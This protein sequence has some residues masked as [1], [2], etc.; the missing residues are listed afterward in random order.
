MCNSL[1]ISCDAIVFLSRKIDMLGAKAGKDVLDQSKALVRST[2]SDQ[3]K[4]L[5]FRVDFGSMEGMARHDMNVF[6]KMLPEGIYLD[7]LAGSLP[8]NN[9]A[10]L[11]C[12]MFLVQQ[13]QVQRCTCSRL[14]WSIQ[15]YDMSDSLSL[16]AVQDNIA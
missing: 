3:D 15:A 14:T 4:R 11:R 7:F 6:R 5:A 1:S 10:L 13:S 12:Y 9:G 8:T 16:Y 2:L